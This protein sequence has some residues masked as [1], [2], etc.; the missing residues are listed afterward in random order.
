VVWRIDAVA[1]GGSI[2]PELTGQFWIVV[3]GGG[4][5]S[6][7][8][9]SHN[10][11]VVV[12]RLSLKNSKASD[13]SAP[14]M[15][16]FGPYARRHAW[17]WWIGLGVVVVS[18]VARLAGPPVVVAQAIDALQNGTATPG[19][20]VEWALLIVAAAAVSGGLFIFARRTVIVASRQITYEVRRDIYNHLTTLDQH[21]YHRT[22]TGDLMNRLTG[23]LNAVQEMFGFGLL[24][25]VS[26]LITLVIS[27]VLMFSLSWQLGLVVL[28][29]FPFIAGFLMLLMREIA[30]RYTA[31]Q[32]QESLISAKAQENFSGAR[33]VK[34][35]AI[36]D[37]EINEYRELNMEY[38]RRVLHLAR[39]E[40]PI[41]ATV[42]L[43]LNV[44][45]V[46]VLILGSRQ[47]LLGNSVGGLSLGQFVQFSTYLFELQWPMLAVGMMANVVQRGSTSWGRLREMLWSKPTIADTSVTNHTISTVAGEIVFDGVS[48]KADG[49][50]LLVDVSLNIPQGQTIG[51]TGRTG[52]GKS[53]LAG[54]IGRL[55][56]P[57]TGRVL[58]D[59]VD[60]RE[61]PL[62]TLRRHI[63]YVPQEPFLFSDTIAENIA[64]GLAQSPAADGTTPAGPDME[65][66]RRAATIAGLAGDVE[67]FPNQY[68]TMLGERGVTLSGG[69]RQRTALARA[70]AR[71]PNIL[72]LDDSMSAVDTETEARILGELK[73]VLQNRTV[74]LIGHRVSTLRHAD[75]IV[76]LDNG[77][78]IEQGSHEALLALGGHYA[79]MERK[80]NLTTILESEDNNPELTE[81]VQELLGRLA[82]TPSKP[83]PGGAGHA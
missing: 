32:E 54:L 46:V 57:S 33:V 3:V 61:W 62:S 78:I 40:G 18:T 8:P 2:P 27:L 81:E 50:Q 24:H 51:I 14:A 4:S 22:R 67:D 76:V 35:Y 13:A 19:K 56:D 43:M 17:Q 9:Y 74:L 66:V 25:G 36:E 71:D 59:G 48:L 5:Q 82:K 58:I 73:T 72:I 37:R 55:L 64:F 38:R 26:T 10:N 44:V 1:G 15:A 52:A 16:G 45:F 28:A 83:T 11:V 60:V 29:V 39:V 68:H 53:L 80:Q 20:L 42:G 47:I 34:G 41:W 23:D 65:R 77:R 7:M 6:A 21:Y 69:Q 75:H 31:K 63:G 49:R 12:W 79:E 30:K 70:I